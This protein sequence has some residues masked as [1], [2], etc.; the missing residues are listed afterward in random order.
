MPRDLRPLRP[1]KHFTTQKPHDTERC[2][3]CIELGHNCRDYVPPAGD[4][5]VD[6]PDDQSI[7]SEASTASSSSWADEQQLSDE[8][9]TPVASEGEE[10][11]D[12]FLDSQMKSLNLKDS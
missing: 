8:D 7:I 11:I 6:I 2:Q 5:A 3:K 10:D 4:A 9:H 12:K 1:S